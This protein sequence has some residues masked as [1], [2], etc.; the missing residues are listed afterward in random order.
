MEILM[1][2]TFSEPRS[3]K[4]GI[5]PII[6]WSFSEYLSTRIYLSAV[7]AANVRFA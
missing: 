5:F 2:G 3:G 1:Y 4:S 6:H 7:I